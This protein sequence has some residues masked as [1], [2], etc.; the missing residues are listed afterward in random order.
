MEET[1]ASRAHCSTARELARQEGF[2]VPLGESGGASDGNFTAALGVPT[3]DG[4]S[5][6]GGGAHTVT[7]RVRL[8]SIA[9]RTA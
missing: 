2:D 8:S 5:A 4:M 1:S 3:L 7:K 9:K 6:V